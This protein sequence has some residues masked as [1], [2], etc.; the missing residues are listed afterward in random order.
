MNEDRTKPT[1]R[2]Y[3]KGGSALLAGGVLAGCTGSN[4]DDASTSANETGADTTSEASTTADE[5]QT[6]SSNDA[7][8]PYSVTM[9]PMGDV[10]F[11]TVPEDALVV[12]PQYAD[13][14]VALGH[15]DGACHRILLIP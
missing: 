15:G 8:S 1:R 6:E 3:L 7:E 2:D 4:R 12:F 9:S 14:A 10:E 11:D 5:S 13:M